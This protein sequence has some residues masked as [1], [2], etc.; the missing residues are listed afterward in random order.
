MKIYI[1][2]DCS[3]IEAPIQALD[4]ICKG[5]QLTY[6]H[7]FSSEID[8][9]AIRCIEDNYKPDI[10]YGD[11]KQRDLKTLPRIDMYISGFPCQPFSIANKFKSPIDPRLNLFM[12]CLDVIFHSRP[13]CFIL[14]NVITLLT[15]DDGSYFRDIIQRLEKD[16]IYMIY[17]SKMN[18]KD[19]GIP[20]SRKRLYIIGI[21]KDVYKK[22]FKFPDKKPMKPLKSFIDESNKNK[23]PIKKANEQL[24]KN[25]PK[26]SLFIDTGFRNCRFPNSGRWAPC[27]TAQPNMWCVPMQRKASVKE[28]LMLQGFPLSFKQPRDISDHQMK[29]KIGNSMT[30][31]VIELLMIDI[32]R[33]LEW[34]T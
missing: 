9:Y 3:G 14:E 32:F 8:P 21:R 15:L 20:Q 33:S 31:D 6:H 5:R 17:S 22:E 27:I 19:Y 10:I 24:F 13:S 29:I 28:Y 34:V 4:N 2:T 11:M 26:D 12:N 18:T 16:N 30:V 23:N 25:I 7:S 1:G